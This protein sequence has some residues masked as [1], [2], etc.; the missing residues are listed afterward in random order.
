LLPREENTKR[1]IRY[2]AFCFLHSG[3][4]RIAGTVV[5]VYSSGNLTSA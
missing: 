1:T 5:V 2:S 3:R 4:C